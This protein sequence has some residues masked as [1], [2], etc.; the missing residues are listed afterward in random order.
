M[1][2]AEPD[3]SGEVTAF[4]EGLFRFT[5]E[6]HDNVCSEVEVGTEI[7]DALAHLFELS[8]RIETVHPF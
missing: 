6:S 2:V 1:D 4:G 8:R 5:R 3:L 7:F